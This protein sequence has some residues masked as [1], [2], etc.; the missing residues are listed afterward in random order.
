M[1][2]Q[3][4]I[5]GVSLDEERLFVVEAPLSEVADETICLHRHPNWPAR[6]VIDESHRAFFEALK[7]SLG[8]ALAKLEQIEFVMIDE[9]D[10]ADAMV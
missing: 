10:D 7:L 9:D 6:V 3:Q 4:L 1:V 8:Q 5:A 2:L